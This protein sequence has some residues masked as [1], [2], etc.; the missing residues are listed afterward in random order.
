[1]DAGEDGSLECGRIG[2]IGNGAEDW[3]FLCD[4][5]ITSVKAAVAISKRIMDIDM[6]QAGVGTMSG[7]RLFDP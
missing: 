7:R 4:L 3:W 2:A 6:I 5:S 1:M